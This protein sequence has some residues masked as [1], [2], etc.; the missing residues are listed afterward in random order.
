MASFRSAKAGT[1]SAPGTGLFGKFDSLV[2]NDPKVAVMMTH[3]D[4][5]AVILCDPQTRSVGVVHAGW[6]GT[7]ANVS[8]AAVRTMIDS[9]GAGPEEV[10][11]FI[12]PGICVDCYAVGDE[13]VEAWERVKPANGD[14]ALDRPN[15]HWHFDLA[16]ANRL[17][18][19]AEGLRDDAIER[20]DICTRCGGSSWFSHRGQGAGDWTIRLH[21]LG[22]RMSETTVDTAL[23]ERLALVQRRVMY[24][25]EKA[26]R[27]PAGVTIVG[28]TKTVDR[29]AVEEAYRLGMRVFGENRV[30]DAKAKFADPLPSDAQLHMI[31]SLQSNKAKVAVGLFDVIQSVDRAS[32]VDALCATGGIDRQNRRSAAGN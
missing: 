3:A 25:A 13:V 5:L 1:G 12:G 9:F 23:A 7:V 27:D 11:A 16:E 14:T 8:G 24:S 32:L 26:N 31:G 6:R 2:T 29:A 21:H 22:G 10:L 17:Q 4:C 28:V 30:Q 15:G 18:L 20:S 19:R